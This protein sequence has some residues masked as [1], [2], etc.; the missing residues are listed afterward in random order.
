MTPA[1]GRDRLSWQRELPRLSDSRPSRWIFFGLF[2][3]A[4]LALSL[5]VR[6]VVRSGLAQPPVYAAP[7]AG[8][9]AYPSVGGDTV[10]VRGRHE[11]AVGD[12]LISLGGRD[13]RGAGYLE[14]MGVAFEQAGSALRAP[15]VYERAGVRRETEL[16]LTPYV[17]PWLRIPFLSMM[18]LLVAFALARRPGDRFIQL[19]AASFATFVIGEAIFE[20]GG[21]AQAVTAKLVFIFGGAV[22]WPLIVFMI[23]GFPGPN[24][25]RPPLAIV[26]W[27]AV[28]NALLF[29][30]PKCMYLLGG[31]V[32]P[33]WIPTFVYAGDAATMAAPAALFAH[34]YVRRY[35]AS[36]RR[37]VKWVVIATWISGVTM[38]TALLMPV[39]DPG[40][41]WFGGLLAFASLT[42]ASI[43]VAAIIAI[44]GYD[45]FALDRLLG[46]TAAYSVLL[47][48]LLAILLA[49]VPPAA[50]V[51]AGGLG[52]DPEAARLALSM[53]V[54]ALVVPLHHWL[55]PRIDHW[56]FPE[57]RRI[58]SGI[59]HLIQEQRGHADPRSLAEA[60]AERLHELFRPRFTAVFQL[61]GGEAAAADGHEPV[62]V[63]GD[64]ASPPPD[65]RP[66]RAL[67]ARLSE[68]S[69]PL[70][71]SERA[72]PSARHVARA[73]GGAF[74]DA[75][76]A[77]LLLPIR[78]GASLPAFLA[79]GA[80]R[81]GDA[82]T[83]TELAL[84]AGALET[85]SRQLRLVREAEALAR[86][87][88][89]AEALETAHLT[90]SR[91]LA[92]ASHDL[93]QPLHAL[94]LFSEA[95]L[96]RAA[97]PESLELAE[98]IRSSSTAVHEM[99]D[100]LIDLSR[101][102]QGTLVPETQAF[103][104]RPLLERL[105]AEAELAAAGKRLR[106][107]LVVSDAVVRSDPVLLGRIVQNL[108]T[109]A[110]RYTDAG[111]VT[112]R[113][114][115]VGGALRIAVEDTGPGIPAS[116]HEAI[117]GEFVRLAPAKSARGLGL[118]LSIVRRLA[119]MLGHDVTLASEVGKG[120]TFALR[121]P[122]AAA[123]GRT[124]SETL[125]GSFLLEQ[126]LL[127]VDDDLEVLAGM[128]S[129]LEGWGT[130]V[131]VAS[132]KQEALEALASGRRFHAILA[133]FRLGDESGVDVIEAVR[134]RLGR[135]VPAVVITGSTS[136]ETAALLEEKRLPMLTKPVSPAR[137]RAAL[138]QL[139]RSA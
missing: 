27:V 20:G 139:L 126:S 97:D 57:R 115:P 17:A 108:L 122:L 30:L 64:L 14:F 101:I 85:A 131:T 72:A 2:P 111:S 11:L 61:G 43:P 37:R 19:T 91:H 36:E 40:N 52:I 3:L 109:N 24:P 44:V 119:G 68:R 46:A 107:D 63:L 125:T 114:E 1:G 60:T 56:F 74:L 99:F 121:V 25:A 92:A 53:L 51:V 75:W 32:P 130:K 70:A 23:A 8:P 104:V 90:R 28:A 123:Q 4:L 116:E 67:L 7:G 112:L 16:Q 134:V 83:P 58:E 117:F 86:E 38:F 45:L 35:D 69:A 132:S 133:D 9:E 105:A 41:P 88:V 96:E 127:L 12:L 81:S 73:E 77:A 48:G 59:E 136:A 128:R 135:P 5:H 120:T 22:W 55:Q 49:I 84:L 87:R 82:F 31:P 118:G 26:P 98:H 124:A 110:V 79:L 129:L 100:A 89:R 10:E 33:D 66:S 39:I 138:A 93:R 13:L 113:A 21:V 95:L 54:A 50:Q 18:L 6:E 94:R 78:D 62:R 102:D 65:A 80:K 29:V 42:A 34:N 137:L 15:L 103:A 47:V 71:V 106:L 76:P